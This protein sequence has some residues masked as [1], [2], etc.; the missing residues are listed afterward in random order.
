[1]NTDRSTP[2][3]PAGGTLYHVI[4]GESGWMWA[5]DQK[6]A[7]TFKDEWRR[8]PWTAAETAAYKK[9]HPKPDSTAA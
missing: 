9:R 2:A 3:A 6:W 5:V 7:L 8:T 4:H 1:M